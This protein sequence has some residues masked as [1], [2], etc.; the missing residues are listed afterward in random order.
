MKGNTK[1]VIGVAAVVAAGFAGY[2]G[3]KAYKNSKADATVTGLGAFTDGGYADYNAQVAARYWGRMNQ[4]Y[5]ERL[6]LR[7]MRGY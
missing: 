3:Y 7:A 4:Q 6:H 5:N 1:I 2:F